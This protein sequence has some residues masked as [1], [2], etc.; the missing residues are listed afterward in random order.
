LSRK[1][2]KNLDEIYEKHSQSNICFSYRAA[3]SWGL[4]GN[5]ERSLLNLRRLLE[6]GWN[7]R[8]SW[9]DEEWKFT[10]NQDHPEYQSLMAALRQQAKESEP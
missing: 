8:R 4:A 3:Q 10:A 5:T 9:L 2:L 6:S 1:E 7:G